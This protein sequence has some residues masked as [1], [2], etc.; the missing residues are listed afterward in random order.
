MTIENYHLNAIDCEYGQRSYSPTS[1]SGRLAWKF[2]DRRQAASLAGT[3]MR[4]LFLMFLCTSSACLANE[5]PAV[6]ETAKRMN[7]S[8]ESVKRHYITGCDSGR[9]SEMAICGAYGSV[10]A[11]LKLNQV[12]AQLLSEIGTK[13]AKAKLISAQRAWIAF[14]DR[15]CDFETD[16]YKKG[17]DF[18]P[19]AFSCQETYASERTKHLENYLGCDGKYGCPGV[20]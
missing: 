7:W 9:P 5:D 18:S 3:K 16:G 15:T 20:E 4:L 10:K 2:Q 13:T 17:R 14:K 12:Y 1:S 6:L 11:D 8:V 19:V